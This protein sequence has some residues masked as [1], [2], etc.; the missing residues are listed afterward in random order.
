MH[1]YVP[2]FGYKNSHN[3]YLSKIYFIKSGVH[4][5]ICKNK[6]IDD[7]NE[8]IYFIQYP[9]QIQERIT[10][11]TKNFYAEIENTNITKLLSEV[12]WS[13]EKN[14]LIVFELKLILNIKR[15]NAKIELTNA[16]TFEIEEF[17]NNDIIQLK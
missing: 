14:N 3:I 5:M 17:S 2:Y 16:Y 1:G 15:T 9:Q 7:I 10:A 13:L 12:A 4:K 11:F 6:N 8:F